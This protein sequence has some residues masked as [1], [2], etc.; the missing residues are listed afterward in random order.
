MDREWTG[1]GPGAQANVEV[2]TSGMNAYVAEACA[3]ARPLPVELRLFSS[4]PD[5]WS[6]DDIVCVCSHSLTRNATCDVA[7]AEV[8]CAAG[9]AANR[10]RQKPEPPVTPKL[11]AGLDPATCPPTC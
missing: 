1:Y 7:R 9:Q 8:A 3:G 2:F 5:S 6:A 11:P 10:V 4:T